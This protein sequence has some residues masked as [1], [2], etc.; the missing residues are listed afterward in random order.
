[1]EIEREKIEVREIKYLEY[2]F[3]AYDRQEGHIRDRVKRAME[4]AGKYRGYGG[5]NSGKTL[6]KV[7]DV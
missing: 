4:I 3:Q 5:G 2:T 6:E 1:M 7:V